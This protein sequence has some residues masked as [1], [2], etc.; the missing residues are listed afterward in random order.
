M[1]SEATV[2]IGVCAHNEEETIGELLDQTMNED[3]PVEEVIVVV[4]GNDRTSEIV[5]DRQKLHDEIKLVE[6]ESREGQIAAQ[7]KM[8]ERS[9]GDLILFLDGDGTIEPGSL[10]ALY[11]SFEPCKAV[12][13]KEIP[14]TD[15]SFL[16]SVIDI[17]GE[18]HHQLCLQNPRFSTHL[19]IFRSNLID[20][21]PEIILDDA[22]IEHLCHLNELEIDYVEDAVKHHN[23]PNTLRFFF[24]Q[25]KK[26][27]AGRFQAKQKG[28][29]HTKPDGL[30]AEVFL[31]SLK[32]SSF[33]DIPYLVTL[34]SLE[35]AAY[36]SARFHQLTGSFPV[37]WWR[38][39]SRSTV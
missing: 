26:N 33:K 15:D 2:S 28:F 5:R 4:A 3:I 38:P 32:E 31:N 36:I 24:H 11:E 22:Y 17:Y 21:F 6:E 9:N 20:S 25:Q 35:A 14:V 23:T 29:I 13:G 19:G 7:N 8:L 16:G 10:E 18:V 37:K 30:L 12:A 27:W 39:E 1:A 34:G